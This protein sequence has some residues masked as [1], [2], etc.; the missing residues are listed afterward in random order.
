MKKI[1]IIIA[2][3]IGSAVLSRADE[4]M[5]MINGIDKALEKQ[6]KQR[7]LKL[8]ANEI[9]NADAP[10]ATISDAIVSL[11]FGCTGS[12]ISD[13]GLVITNHH[14]AY[15]DV[16]ALST[17]EKNYLED[18]FWAMTRDEEIPI[19]GKNM[20]FL[21]RVLD[22]TDEVNAMIEEITK[23]GL[24]YGMR[25]IS[26][27]IEKKYSET[28]D[29]LEA[30]LASMWSGE[31]YYMM[32]YKVYS[33]IRLVA[34][35]PVSIAAY[36]GD[37]DNWEWPQHKC[38]FAMYRI[39]T[40]PDGSPAEYSEE[41]IPLVPEAKLTISTAGY[42][43]GDFTMVIGY[44]GSTNRY[45]SAAEVDFE[46]TVTLPVSNRLRGDQMAIIN[47]H[48]NSDPSIRLKYS[49]YYF[50]LSNVQELNSGKE[51]NIRRFDVTGRKAAE[52]KALQAWI[53]ADAGR[54]ARWGEVIPMLNDKY[55]AV[56][57]AER[58]ITYYRETLVRGT[59]ISRMVTRLNIL[60]R[61]VLGKHGIKMRTSLDK[62]GPDSAEVNCCRN[63]RFC[64]M[65]YNA[66]KASLMNEYENI[67]LA[68]E[69]D[70]FKYSIRE[71]YLNMRPSAI[72]PYQKELQATFTDGNGV[73]DY[74]ALTD[75]LWD[76]SFLTDREKVQEFVNSD[77]T[78]DEYFSDPVYR[79]FE[80]IEI[81]DMN[82][83]VSGIEGKP[84]ILALKKEFTHAMYEKSVEDGLAQ[85]P[86]A[87]STMRITYGTVGDIQ[88]YDAV[89]WSW[90]STSDGILE[91]Y[92]PSSYEFSLDPRQK[93]LLEEG[94]WGPWAAKDT[95]RKYKMFVN[96]LTDN[97]ITGGNSG[98]PVMNARGEL[99]GLAFDGNKESLASDVYYVDDYTKC[100]CVDI[101]FVLWVL[102]RYAG[103]D[104]ILDEIGVA[105]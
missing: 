73:C 91:K 92:D 62:N 23:K 69:K 53:D 19:P 30:S 75:W 24:P 39:Y 22:V 93:S 55:A 68:V 5:W 64:G 12:V 77:H 67:D 2:V 70:L 80:D 31:K 27:L 90:R 8:S 11:D 89:S 48:M 45:S 36:G 97:D 66:V 81:F 84:S 17:D 4:G 71:F 44:P 76:N 35:P 60:K 14:C 105:R 103:M 1:L 54:K 20:L 26:Y 9:Y 51:K 63:F 99:I 16:H 7:G 57:D 74:N 38:D 96:F 98:S 85:Y 72:G 78:L 13:E 15:G 25:K 58:D 65:D 18:G 28:S 79:F 101:R 6:M 37:I 100:V 33:D 95:D 32:F 50:G 102:D 87:N 41:N 86:N 59:K 34:A 82:R 21:K 47:R 88:P 49:D 3:F 56:K 29:G 83:V 46:E 40:A 10:G 43:P 52:E 94:D 104:Y 61:E 42:K